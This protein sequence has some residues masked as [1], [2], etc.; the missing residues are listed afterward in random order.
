VALGD[1]SFCELDDVVAS[2]GGAL[3]HGLVVGCGAGT[4][5]VAV[6]L[7]VLLGRFTIRF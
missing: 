7:L 1:S 3:T 4:K 2:A 5:L 6:V